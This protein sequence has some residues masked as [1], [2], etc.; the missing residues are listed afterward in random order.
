MLS[1][2]LHLADL[3]NPSWSWTADR[4]VNGESWIKPL[5]NPALDYKLAYDISGR[6]CA[7]VRERHGSLASDILDA[8][9]T[10]P[11]MDAGTVV[12]AAHSWPGEHITVEMHPRQ[13]RIAAGPFGTAPLYLTQ[14]SGVL[15]GSWNLPD[16]RPYLTPTKLLDRAV[17]RALTRQPRYSSDTLFEGVY[18]LTERA[19]ATFT[20]TQLSIHYPAPAEHVL[21]ARK[22][23]RG[24]DIVSI[25][26]ELLKHHV[27]QIPAR[28]DEVGV[29]LSGG[30]D[31]ANVALTV[32]A[33]RDDVVRSYGL[34]VDGDVGQQQRRRRTALAQR[35]GL[36]DTEVTASGYPPFSPNGIRARGL[37]HDPTAA[38]YREAFDALRDAVMDHKTRVIF[39]GLGGD[40][41]NALHPHEQPG[42]RQSPT[43]E[44]IPWLGPVARAAAPDVD[45]N[46][47]PVSGVPLPTLTAFSLHNPT[48]LQAGIWPVAPLAHPVIGR[49][50][51]Q[52]P[53]EWRQGKALFRQRLQRAGFADEIANPRQPENFRGLMQA[54]L[55]RF[56]LP[57]LKEM[58]RE[59]ILVDTGYLDHGALAS[60]YES[61]STAATVPSVLCDAIAIESGLHSL[62]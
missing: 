19:T 50:A 33:T 7:V 4:W 8:P 39:T 52:L 28:P 51:E 15:V 60:A 21:Q 2:R 25:F 48:Y 55:R 10:F 27:A 59:S 26:H 54:G 49:F 40:E 58:L 41:I 43:P 36:L 16:L 35:L 42:S 5:V 20:S 23:R 57:R 14:C 6:A 3:S 45:T 11:V 56:G 22:V 61:A 9:G 38:Y 37:P 17:V 13:V 30:A 18:R 12:S 31:S 29:E 32:A 34:I 1:L 53:Q 46:L 44:P 24:I 62:L 47:A